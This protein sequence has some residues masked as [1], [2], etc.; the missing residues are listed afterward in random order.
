MQGFTVKWLVVAFVL[1]AASVGAAPERTVAVQLLANPPYTYPPA[2]GSPQVTGF[3]PDLF[4]LLKVPGY[5]WDLQV[6]PW[7]RALSETR[8]DTTGFVVL[9]TLTRTAEREADFTWIAPLVSSRYFFLG[10]GPENAR[11]TIADL[12][13]RPVVVLLANTSDDWLKSQ[14]FSRVYEV[15]TVEQ[16]VKMVLAG[17]AE[18][19]LKDVTSLSFFLRANGLGPRELV[20]GPEVKALAQPLYLAGGPRLDATLAGALASGLEKLRQS[21]ELAR[22]WDRWQ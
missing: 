11:L 4:A 6:K 22:L 10:R 1:V 13:D 16:M 18:Y 12:K 2:P 15:A 7:A 3:L 21:G 5:R 14:G 9:P 8:E 17:R 20:L 19:L